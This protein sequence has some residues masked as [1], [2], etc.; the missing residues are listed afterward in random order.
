MKNQYDSIIIGGGPAGL[1]A[2]VYLGRFLRR[3]LII[4][5]KDGRWNSFEQN[6]NYLGFPD[7][8]LARTLREKGLVQAQKFGAEYTIDVVENV[9][10][11]ENSF[12]IIT[13]SETYISKTI[14]F[15]TGVVDTFPKFD[16]WQ[17]CVGKSLFWCITCDGYETVNKK[18]MVVGTSN[19]AVCSALQFLQYTKDIVFVTNAHN[20]EISDV[21]IQRL[22]NHKIPFIQGTIDSIVHTQGAIAKVIVSGRD[23]IVEKIFSEQGSVPQSELAQKI[24][25]IVN[26]FGYIETDNEQRTNLAYCY[27][28]G[29]VTRSFAHQIT[30]AVHE[31]AMAAQSANYDLY[32]DFQR[33]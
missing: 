29:D 3:T 17:E 5:K 23:F 25:V 27:A 15:A 24:G 13:G 16:N 14:I 30:T 22:S 21:W 10:Q 26:E 7:G 9:A 33:I 18:I 20:H 2:A 4:D 6:R 28:A 32:A 8:I 19:D 11:K 1:S 31:G 12:E